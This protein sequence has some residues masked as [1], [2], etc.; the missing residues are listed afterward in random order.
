MSGQAG[1]PA[2]RA[3][4]PRAATAE[5]RSPRALAFD[6]PAMKAEWTLEADTPLAD[7]LRELRERVGSDD[8]LERLLRHGGLHLNRKRLCDFDEPPGLL[9]AGTHVV[10]YWFEREPEPLVLPES[11][12]I[13]DEHGLVAV[14]KPPWWT[15]QGTRASRFA[16][17]ERALRAALGCPRLTPVNRIDRETS[18]VLLFARDTRAAAEAGRQFIA[19]TV[20]K[21]YLAAVQPEPGIPEAWEVRGHV[22]R[23][24]HPS[25]SLFALREGEGDQVSSRGDIADDRTWSL[26]SF[27]TFA[28]LPAATLVLA[29]PVTGRTHQIRVHLAAR[30][31]SILGD[32]LYG[33]GWQPGAPFA[34]ER[35][36]LHARAVTL[37]V[38]GRETRIEAPLPADFPGAGE[39]AA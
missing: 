19:R 12:V 35:M 38:G 15:T 16:S 14:N 20:R 33:A 4:H 36:L 7:L 13:H 24:E 17:L 34:T 3:H 22:V 23:V 21:E 9:A 39:S 1:G 26:T 31:L 37:R 29:R 2:A 25:H 32:S 8:A 5:H 27:E 18:G 10:A 6:P 28:R 11:C 30:G